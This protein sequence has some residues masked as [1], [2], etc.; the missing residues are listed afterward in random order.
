MQR[1]VQR[2]VR[3][4]FILFFLLGEG[5]SL[6]YHKFCCFFAYKVVVRRHLVCGVWIPERTRYES[7]GGW[8]LSQ[9]IS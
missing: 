4:Y 6:D 2:A 3:S 8:L 7:E 5:F 9:V 1:N